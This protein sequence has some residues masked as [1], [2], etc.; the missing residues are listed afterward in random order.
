MPINCA[1]ADVRSS[2][3]SRYSFVRETDPPSCAKAIYF[4][5]KA[6]AISLIKRLFLRT[7]AY[8]SLNCC[9]H[10]IVPGLIVKCYTDLFSS[11]NG[12]STWQNAAIRS[13][14]FAPIR[15]IV[16][17]LEKKKKKK[18]SERKVM[19]R[20]LLLARRTKSRGTFP[21]SD[22]RTDCESCKSNDLWKEKKNKKKPFFQQPTCRRIKRGSSAFPG[23]QTSRSFARRQPPTSAKREKA[24]QE[25]ASKKSAAPRSAG[26]SHAYAIAMKPVPPSVPP[27][28]RRLLSI[29]AS[30]Y[31]SK[32]NERNSRG[33]ARS[34]AL[35][36]S[37][38]K[39]G[40]PST[41]GAY[42]PR[43]ICAYNVRGGSCPW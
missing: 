27:P 43:S 28:I 12:R 40:K 23:V 36:V 5:I 4:S 15:L 25:T 26:R 37:A 38:I 11:V 22:S 6:D 2:K 24:E 42:P 17:L 33:Q 34:T 1:P 30:R 13:L 9:E 35:G 32:F 14:L 29:D 7:A 21:R 39:N 8:P 20:V 19:T 3:L 10:E 18:K 41:H 16:R 31:S